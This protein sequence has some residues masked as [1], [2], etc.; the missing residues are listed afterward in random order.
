MVPQADSEADALQDQFG[1]TFMVPKKVDWEKEM[2][3]VMKE[4]GL[5]T[6]KEEED[7]EA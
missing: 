7:E 6:E 2:D 4:F 3:D 5:G 1:S